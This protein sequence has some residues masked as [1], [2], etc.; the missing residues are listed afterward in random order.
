MAPP[1]QSMLGWGHLARMDGEHGTAFSASVA[2]HVDQPE[3][4]PARARRLAQL[5]LQLLVVSLDSIQPKSNARHNLRLSR[6]PDRLVA[7]GGPDVWLGLDLAHRHAG[8]AE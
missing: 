3:L 8:Q 4:W 6:L 1:W 5:G 7:G 2:R